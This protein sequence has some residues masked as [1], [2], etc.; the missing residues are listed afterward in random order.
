MFYSNLKSSVLQTFFTGLL[1]DYLA[2]VIIDTI[3][4]NG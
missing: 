3:F 4:I 1:L 2:L